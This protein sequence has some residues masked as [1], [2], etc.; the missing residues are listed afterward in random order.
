MALNTSTLLGNRH[1]HPLQNHFIF[2]TWKS[3]P[4]K[5]QLPAPAPSRRPLSTYFSANV[6]LLVVVQSLRHV[7]LTAAPWTASRQASLSLTISQ[8]LPKFMSIES[9]MLS[10]YL[11]LCH[12]LLLPSI[13]P[14]IRAFSTESA[15]LIRWPKYWS[16]T[17][18]SVLPTNMQD[19]FL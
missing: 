16:F 17:S 9:V 1:H 14:S 2:P 7:W 15:L 3:A 13:L 12:P 10:K 6:A 11:I 5:Q 19:W 4:I 8:D 18:A